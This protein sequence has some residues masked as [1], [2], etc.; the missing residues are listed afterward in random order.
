VLVLKNTE[1]GN[2]VSKVVGIGFGVGS[3]NPDKHQQATVNLPRNLLP[4]ANPRAADA[5]HNGTHAGSFK[6]L[7]SSFKWLG[8][9]VRG[10]WHPSTFD[11]IQHEQ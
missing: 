2:L 3:A 4:H 8:N 10:R 1:A 7:V 5:L 11:R 9:N 6:S